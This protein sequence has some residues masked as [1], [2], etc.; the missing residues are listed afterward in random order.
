MD[1]QN[2]KY[3]NGLIKTR[4]RLQ[5]EL[6]M[7]EEE[8][9]QI[10]SNCSHVRV[11]V[12]QDKKGIFYNEC[13]FCRLKEIPIEL[14]VP[15]IVAHH[16]K[17]DI[18]GLGETEKLRESRMEEIRKLYTTFITKNDEKEANITEFTKRI[19]RGLL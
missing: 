13:L 8:L 3:S 9:K 1:V 19:E 2:L 5:K 11:L 7:I 16:F 17:S 10:Q 14:H 6:I 15:T 4:G 12:G 18:Y